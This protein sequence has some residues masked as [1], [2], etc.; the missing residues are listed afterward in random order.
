MHFGLTEEQQE[1]TKAVKGLIERRA[2][3]MDV[4][5]AIASEAGYDTQLWNDLV[6][7]I[8]VAALAVPEEFGGAG[9]TSFETHVVL[10]QL[11]YALSP[12]PLLG[13]GIVAAQAVL[14][15]AADDATKERLLS[16]IAAGTVAALAWADE[17]GRFSVEHGPLAFDPSTGTL[18][19]T[20]SLVLE[21]ADAEILL[22]LA[23]VDGTPTLLEVAAQATGLTRVADPAMDQTLRLATWTLDGTPATAL[24]ALDLAK[25][26]AIA[27]T[28]VTALQTGGAR[29]AL[30]NT[31]AYLKEREQFERPLGSFQAL[32]HR[33]AD[34]LVK[35][36][37][38]TSMSWAA[39]W[40]VSTD[41]PD[42]VEKAALASSWC[43]E[44][45]DMVAG[46]S[47][48]LFGGIAIT[49]EHSAHLYFKRALACSMLFG[50][51]HEVRRVLTDA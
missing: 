45:F 7:Q 27:K 37:V 26:R 4:T 44:A 6:E 39:A 23:D 40:S 43:T 9:F 18:S 30:D 1:L 31:V 41:Q 50:R 12:S 10:E 17:A 8:G 11:G 35:V 2:G 36:E 28:A 15:S 33:V 13:S 21:G 14:Q 47:I 42:L 34:M 29:A 19:G 25:L 38:S 51:T 5:A 32:K 16:Q 49:W 46:E 22:A 24:G 48:Q 3:S 20:A